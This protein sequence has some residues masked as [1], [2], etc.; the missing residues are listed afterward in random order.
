LTAKETQKAK[1]QRLED[2]LEEKKKVIADL[3]ERNDLL[4][5]DILK[6]KETADKTFQ[7]SSHYKQLTKDIELSKASCRSLEHRYKLLEER[8]QA[9]ERYIEKLESELE[10]QTIEPVQK[11]NERG[12]GRKTKFTP[13]QV[14]L[15]RMDR[16]NGM[17]LDQLKEKYH[18]SYGLIHKLINDN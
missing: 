7:N 3:M 18:C 16:A 9:R 11:K 1:I 4:Y 5:K 15:I 2:T 13:E 10:N 17:T 12:A 8:H 6:M 14:E